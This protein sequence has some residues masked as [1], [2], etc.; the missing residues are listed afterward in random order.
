MGKVITRRTARFS[1]AALLISVSALCLGLASHARAQTAQNELFVSA[2][3]GYLLN[4]S[5]TNFDFD[6]AGKF[7]DLDSL[8]PGEDGHLIGGTIGVPLS[9]RMDFRASLI[10]RS[11]GDDETSFFDV[12]TGDSQ[13]GTASMAVR[14]F[15]LEL[16]Y[17]PGVD[18]LRIFAGARL[19]NMSNRI[20]YF[21]LDVDPLFELSLYDYDIDLWGVGP[22]LG[23]E[24]VIPLGDSRVSLLLMGAGSAI[25]AEADED[26]IALD[27]FL[28][29]ESDSRGR[30]IYNLEGQVAIGYD[31]TDSI[32]LQVGYQAEQW[33]RL[34][35]KFEEA[36]ENGGDYDGGGD[37]L[38]HGPFARVT[39]KLP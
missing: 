29:S 20:D 14:T 21:D 3:G 28:A 37:V 4:D 17:R 1:R 10:S 6:D 36:D 25:F 15:D 23:A 30:T 18:R 24:A 35:S 39:V 8:S 2:Y 13:G 19:L 7:G 34:T 38:S 22:R 5:E 27:G 32:N 33:W 31:M 9:E 11:F 26:F 16:G 12:A